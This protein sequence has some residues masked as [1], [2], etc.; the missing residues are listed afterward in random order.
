MQRSTGAEHRLDAGRG[1]A[2]GLTHIAVML[3]D[4]DDAYRTVMAEELARSGFEVHAVATGSAA[5]CAAKA[6][7]PQVVLLDLQLPDMNGLDVLRQIRAT[8]PRS[9]VI[10]VTGQGSIESAVEAVQAGAADYVSKPCPLAELERRVARA[11]PTSDSGAAGAGGGF[12]TLDEMERAHVTRA[13]Q[14][15]AGHRGR[16]AQMLGVSERSLYRL[17]AR[18]GIA[19]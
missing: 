6:R 3:V 15:S 7:A 19:A 1:A 5:V 11:L 14:V 13:L 18:H 17:L 8:S 9:A 2:V 10:M 16:A 4:D 12:P